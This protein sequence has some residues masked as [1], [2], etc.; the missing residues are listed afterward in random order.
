MP[1]RSYNHNWKK[2]KHCNPMPIQE[3]IRRECLA[4][5]LEC[6]GIIMT[7]EK[8]L[9]Q[10]NTQAEQ[11]DFATVISTIEAHY[12]YTPQTFTNGVGDGRVTNSA[13]TNEGS[14]KI[15][16]FAQL[17]GLSE[18]KTLKL[19]GEHYRKVLV[20]PDETDHANIRTFMRHG[21]EGINF[22]APALQAKA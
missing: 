4:D 21:W 2:S 12:N 11:I 22:S 7:I 5:D 18:F 13:G 1:W 6:R 14:C 10:L 19:F 8:L 20:T 3:I 16:A 15:F 9:N 17:Q